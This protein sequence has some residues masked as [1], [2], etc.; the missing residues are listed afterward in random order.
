M[1]LNIRYTPE[2]RVQL[3]DTIEYGIKMSTLIDK[4]N[5]M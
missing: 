3:D 4:L 5:N 2:I 1:N